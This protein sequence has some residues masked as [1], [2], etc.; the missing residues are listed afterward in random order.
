MGTKE[1][2][3][4]VPKRPEESY[5]GMS[6]SCLGGGDGVTVKAYKLHNVSMCHFL[7]DSF[8]AVNGFL[9]VLAGLRGISHLLPTQDQH[10]NN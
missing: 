9:K 10:D 3:E 6:S 7:Y 8:I 4:K 5:K 1:G 2:G